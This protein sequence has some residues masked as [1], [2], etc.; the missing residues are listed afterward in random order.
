MES[1]PDTK[2]R[3]LEYPVLAGGAA[4]GDNE[5]PSTAADRLRELESK[6]RDR[7]REFARMLES[8]RS[9]AL[10]K[11]R[12][13]AVKERAA[14]REECS[15]QLRVAIE[16]FRSQ[17]DDYFAHVEHEVVRLALAV[18]ERILH[19]EAQMD[20]LLLSGAVRVA[21]GQLAESTKVRLR[22]PSQHQ[23]MWGEMVRLV[24]GLP[25]R[26]EVVA[27]P[28]LQAGA[29]FL[30]SSLGV[31]DLGVRTQLEEAERGFF[32]PAAGRGDTEEATKQAVGAGKQG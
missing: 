12:Q 20:P 11:G 28:A 32:D 21:L 24:P 31:V 22:V 6:L 23:E 19:R 26:P 1:Q 4:A 10:E 8:A 25:L 14:W 5:S 9:E 16:E 2:V 29:A 7:E 17:R 18:A 15:V 30:E 3:R 27:D 13:T